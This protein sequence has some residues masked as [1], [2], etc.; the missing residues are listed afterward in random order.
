MR[1]VHRRGSGYREAQQLLA[2]AR[3]L[4]IRPSHD[5][6]RSW[7][8][9]GK[10]ASRWCLQSATMTI[11]HVFLTASIAKAERLQAL[12]RRIGSP[13]CARAR[14]HRSMLNDLS[15]KEGWFLHDRGKT[16]GEFFGQEPE[17]VLTDATRFPGRKPTCV[18]RQNPVSCTSHTTTTARALSSPDG[19]S[20][21]RSTSAPAVLPSDDLKSR[22]INRDLADSHSVGKRFT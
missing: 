3:Y 5:K 20:T 2:T 14:S 13:R 16:G 9:M 7:R 17:A 6:M 12:Y 1:T 10:R 21:S 22:R 19:S 4:S 18:T 15:R 8:R 11:F